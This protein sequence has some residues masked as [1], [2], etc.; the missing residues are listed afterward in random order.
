MRHIGERVVVWFGPSLEMRFDIGVAYRATL[1]SAGP[2]VG[3]S[4][5]IVLDDLL[6]HFGA[7]PCPFIGPLEVSSDDVVAMMVWLATGDEDKK[8]LGE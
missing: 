2:L 6:R 3:R 7:G 4:F 1:K 8:L 5:R